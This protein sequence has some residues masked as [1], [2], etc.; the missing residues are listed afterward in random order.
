MKK[1][2]PAVFAV[3]LMILFTAC[4]Y[5]KADVLASKTAGTGAACADTTGVVS[6]SQKVVPILQQACYGCHNA[7][8]Q[9][10]GILMG[11]YASDKA[12]ALNGKVYGTI[13]YAPGYSPMPKGAAK[14]S[15]CQIAVIKKWVDSG[16]LNN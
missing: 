7:S 12:I 16:I 3:S 6:Y 15:S 5:D 13:A 2:I 14:L 10:G 9:S 4:Y 8:S 1:I 11:T